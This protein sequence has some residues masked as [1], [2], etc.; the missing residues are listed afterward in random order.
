MR[1]GG[2]LVERHA[3]DSK[4]ERA[5]ARASAAMLPS[6][7]SQDLRT[8]QSTVYALSRAG[9]ATAAHRLTALASETR[10]TDLAQSARDAAL[11]IRR[12]GT[13][14]PTEPTKDDLTRLRER[15]EQAEKRLQQLEIWR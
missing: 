9:D 13:P 8:R 10:L 2:W 1:A 3:D 11:A 5:R 12:R 7:D 4:I 15:L 6:L 14:P